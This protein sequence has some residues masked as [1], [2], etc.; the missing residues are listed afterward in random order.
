VGDA[1]AEQQQAGLAELAGGF[2]HEVKN[3]LG[4]LKLN[5][6]NLAED[7]ED[8]QTPRDRRVR[9][10][11]DRML[12]ECARLEEQSQD[13]LRFVRAEAL[14]LQP[15]DLAE[16]VDEQVDFFAPSAR[17]HG[18]QVKSY[19]P[20][21][22]PPVRLD[23]EAFKQALL[24]L[25]LNAQQA[26]P[27]GGGEIT[28]QAA[29]EPP[30]VVL[31]VIDTGKGMPPEVLA[32]AFRPFYSTRPGGTGLGL[33]TTKRIVEAHGGTLVAESEPGRGTRFTIRLPA[34][35]ERSAP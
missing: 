11:I 2:I 27:E 23:R 19:L 7:F 25:L 1:V 34:A 6:Q 12:G 18:V 32:R 8:P 20:A 30:E 28:L 26:M 5:L 15:A 9:E 24:N 21:G 10:R 16:V 3:R 29:H 13:F 35:P 4:T 22:L 33:S 31:R 14:D 17:T